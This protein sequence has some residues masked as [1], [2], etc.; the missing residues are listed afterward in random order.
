MCTR[1]VNSYHMMMEFRPHINSHTPIYNGTGG[2]PLFPNYSASLRLVSRQLMLLLCCNNP[3][4]ARLQGWGSKCLEA[5]LHGWTD[6]S[7]GHGVE[8]YGIHL[9]VRVTGTWYIHPCGRAILYV[10]KTRFLGVG[11]LETPA[12]PINAL[13]NFRVVLHDC[14][15]DETRPQSRVGMIPGVGT[16]WGV[17]QRRQPS[18]SG[19][20]CMI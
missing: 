1:R 10:E 7:L 14:R 4:A 17:H 12:C 8:N 13:S 2:A 5:V 11:V 16:G 9:D 6:P 15:I 18:V 19:C 20:R 3:V